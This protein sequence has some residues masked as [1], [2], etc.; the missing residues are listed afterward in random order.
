MGL[1]VTGARGRLKIRG[2]SNGL[3]TVLMG[4]AIECLVEAYALIGGGG[5]LTT[6]RPDSD[7]DHRDF[8]VDEVGGYVTIYLQVKGSP[9]LYDYKLKLF[10]QYP[11]GEVLSDPRLVY[12]FCLL[13][14]EALRISH[15]WVIPAPAF[16]RLATRTTLAGGRVRLG[17]QAGIRGKGKWARFEIEPTLLGAHL[18]EIVREQSRRRSVPK[19]RV[20]KA[21]Q[22]KAGRRRCAA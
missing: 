20:R 5:R 4:Y 9:R 17:F 12:I 15:M 18:L 21:A 8:I 16:N 2:R 11:K 6:A 7:V 14:A 1:L 13:D 3:P 10:V 19:R 22:P